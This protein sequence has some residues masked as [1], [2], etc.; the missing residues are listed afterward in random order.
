MFKL[1]LSEEDH[2]KHEPHKFDDVVVCRPISFVHMFSVISCIN[3]TLFCLRQGGCVNE[4][5]EEMPSDDETAQMDTEKHLH[6][7]A[8][9]FKHTPELNFKI[10]ISLSTM[11]S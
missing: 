4:G 11:S 9:S 7:G 2:N 3:F 8:I 5:D 6:V 1:W 10:N